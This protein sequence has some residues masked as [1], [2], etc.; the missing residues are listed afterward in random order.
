[1]GGRP[2][3]RIASEK[4]RGEGEGLEKVLRMAASPSIIDSPKI[5]PIPHARAMESSVSQWAVHF[6]SGKMVPAYPSGVECSRNS[7]KRDA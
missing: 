2:T 1:M 6:V 5:V 7:F 3:R 4:R